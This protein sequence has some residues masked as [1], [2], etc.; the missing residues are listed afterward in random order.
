M[1]KLFTLLDDLFDKLCSEDPHAPAVEEIVLL[2]S[3]L[4]PVFLAS[5]FQIGSGS[6]IQIL[7][8]SSQS[9]AAYLLNRLHSNTGN[10]S[11]D[12]RSI[13]AIQDSLLAFMLYLST[14]YSRYYDFKQALP[15]SLQ[16]IIADALASTYKKI[17]S[18]ATR[19][20]LDPLLLQ[21]LNIPIDE[22]KNEQIPVN[23]M[24]SQYLKAV[25]NKVENALI[26]PGYG[27][28]DHA[29]TE[30]L[31]FMNFNHPHFIQY[32]VDTV[33]KDVEKLNG[34]EERLH[35][36]QSFRK[37]LFYLPVEPV[38]S[39]YSELNSC[40]EVLNKIFLQEIKELTE[41]KIS[42]ES[43]QMLLSVKDSF[44]KIRTC[45]SVEQFSL[46]LRLLIESGIIQ[47]KNLSE[48]VNRIAIGF[49]TTKT[50]NIT[51]DSLRIKY[52]QN[53]P[54]AKKILKEYLLQMMKALNRSE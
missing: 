38:S 31:L 19:S 18:L 42:E 7:V 27:T 29:V 28:S 9:T 17:I 1:D 44:P 48:L 39:L 3:Q 45:L 12:K 22:L 5:C 15:V 20:K 33:W 30:L 32:M 51:A 16:Q 50:K 23:F 21:M 10:K 25:L 52:Y 40:R 54:A 41:Q 36:L 11:N 6:T 13:E 8:T 47:Y 53:E 35:L 24:Q 4:K 49:E 14:A 34:I 26:N 2:T 37:K 43:R 46:F